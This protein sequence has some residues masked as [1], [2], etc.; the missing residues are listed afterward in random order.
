MGSKGLRG[1]AAIDHWVVAGDVAGPGRDSSHA[2]AS[3]ISSCRPL[4]R[5]AKTVP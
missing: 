2:T 3:T 1:D 4:R 5:F